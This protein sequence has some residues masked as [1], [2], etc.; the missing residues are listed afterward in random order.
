MYAIIILSITYH[1]TILLS[2]LLPYHTFTAPHTQPL[3]H[4]ELPLPSNTG[5][6]PPPWVANL[7]NTTRKVVPPPWLANLINTTRNHIQ[8]ACNYC[9]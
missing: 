6:V 2:L 3:P 8:A 4:T 1:L 9:N 7:I 5:V